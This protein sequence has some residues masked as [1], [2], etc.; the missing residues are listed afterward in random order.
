[1]PI[2]INK[3]AAPIGTQNVN[4]VG[5]SGADPLNVDTGPNEVIIDD[6]TPVDVNVTNTVTVQESAGVI[7]AQADVFYL[8]TSGGSKDML[9][10]GSSTPVEFSFV[11]S[12]DCI[13]ESL[14]L[15]L[16]SFLNNNQGHSN[17]GAVDGLN[18]GLEI[19]T[20]INSVEI[21]FNHDRNIHNNKDLLLQSSRFQ[22]IVFSRSGDE[23][24]FYQ[25]TFDFT[26]IAGGGIFL[27]ASNTDRIF[28]N[29]QDNLTNTA[30]GTDSSHGINE[31]KANV[32]I[33]RAN[34]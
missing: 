27:D 21:E 11:P 20:E 5:Q 9:V 24:T 19:T 30:A 16:G 8:Q 3:A 26:H 25:V 4:I 2:T 15:Q 29:V 13:V 12:R 7:T 6:S 22:E 28:I 17:F 10:N 33:A 18:N 31:L 32:K 34:A 23:G 1:M 14:T